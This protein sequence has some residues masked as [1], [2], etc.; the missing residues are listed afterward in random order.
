MRSLHDDA[1]EKL[2]NAISKCIRRWVQFSS[3]GV[4]GNNY[5]DVVTEKTDY[6]PSNEYEKNG[7]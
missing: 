1:T 7:A 6:Y 3:I 5:D 2:S 4:Y